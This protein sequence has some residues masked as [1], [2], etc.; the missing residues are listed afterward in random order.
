[1]SKVKVQLL[2]IEKWWD[3][4]L[5]SSNSVNVEHPPHLDKV[6]GSSPALAAYQ[7][8]SGKDGKMF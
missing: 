5:I 4:I 3:G 7:L 6:E 2:L 1:M 8:E